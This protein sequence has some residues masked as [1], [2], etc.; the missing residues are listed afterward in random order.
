MVRVA[1]VLAAG[2]GTRMKS[3]IP[4]VLHRVCGRPMLSW[5]VDALEGLREAGY[6]DRILVVTGKGADEVEREVCDQAT[7]VVQEEKGRHAVMTVR[8]TSTPTNCWSSR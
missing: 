2:E 4:K 6:I 5:V 8:P 1:L 7:C 3:D